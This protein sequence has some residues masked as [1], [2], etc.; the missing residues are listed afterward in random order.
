MDHCGLVSRLEPRSTSNFGRRINIP[1]IARLRVSI[2]HGGGAENRI[3]KPFFIEGHFMGS[4]GRAAVPGRQ[5][6]RR[7][8]RQIKTFLIKCRP[9]RN[10][11]HSVL[12]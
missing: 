4:G 9:P 5:I 11:V 3:K 12:V 6:T 2:L 7:D 1:A 10:T 8:P